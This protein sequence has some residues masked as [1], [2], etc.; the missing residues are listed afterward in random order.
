VFLA[1]SFLRLIAVL[2]DLWLD[3]IWSIHLSRL[4]SSPLEILTKLTHD[5]NHP[6]NTLYLLALGDQRSMESY[7]LL[8]L[9]SGVASVG[10]MGIIGRRY[11]KT[12][13][14]TSLALGGFS[15]LMICYSSEARGYAPAVFFSLLGFLLAERNA[16]DRNRFLIVLF[17]LTVLLGLLSHSTYVFAYSGI[18]AWSAIRSW[19]SRKRAG[20]VALDLLGTHG[21]PLVLVAA[22]IIW[23]NALTIGGGPEYSIP[24]VILETVRFS[25]GLPDNRALAII[26]CVAAGLLGFREIHALWRE[27]RDEW[28]FHLAAILV[29]P[30][31][32][33][34]AARPAVL[35]P[36]YFLVCVPFLLL[37]LARW[38]S[39]W[40]R[41]EIPGKVLY[42][43]LLALYCSL[44]LLQ[45]V[46]LAK[47][48]RGQYSAALEYMVR[49]TPGNTVTVGSDHDFR[50]G[51]LVDFYSRRLADGRNVV[52][53]PGAMIRQDAAPE[54][55][56]AHRVPMDRQPPPVSRFALPG[57]SGYAYQSAFPSSPLSGFHWYV[58]RKAY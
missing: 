48:G 8:S 7:R 32:V 45:F 24:D 26:A 53:V 55:F 40:T 20:H 42:A 49:Q 51:M 4:V 3:E 54:W 37:L 43:S 41:R 47:F 36:R 15:Y 13:S 5:N 18:F 34:V 23:L 39:R 44:N 6:L 50:N 16:F 28:I 27:S 56:I 58:Y 52:Y 2:N 57:G 12:E 33:L 11:G 1:A 14:F 9:L 22:D 25:F 21:I 35:F 17:W 31:L 38:M 29:S 10:L 30:A 19:K 46:D